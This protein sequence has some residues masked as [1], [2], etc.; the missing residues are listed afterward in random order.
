MR[1]NDWSRS[2]ECAADELISLEK[3]KGERGDLHRRLWADTNFYLNHKTWGVNQRFN[4]VDI[5]TI[6]T[7]DYL[8]YLEW[9][10]SKNS[11][12]KPATMNHISSAFSKVLKLARDRGVINIVPALPR[13]ARQDNPRPYFRFYPLVSKADDEYQ[14]LLDTAKQM[15]T[16]EVRVRESVITDELRDL[17]IFLVHSFIRPI[18]TE[19][20]ADEDVQFSLYWVAAGAGDFLVSI[21]VTQPDS[22]QPSLLKCCYKY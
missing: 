12:L 6:T 5:S 22:A 7:V 17:V 20:Y 3:A 2:S 16:D 13:T 10:R 21:F 19:L 14:K 4:K 9:V 8:G 18:E 15:A 11:K 1:W